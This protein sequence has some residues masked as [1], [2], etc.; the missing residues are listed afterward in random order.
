M[1]EIHFVQSGIQIFALDA[2]LA[3]SLTQMVSV[4]KLI[5]RVKHLIKLLENAQAATVDILFQIMVF[6]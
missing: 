1:S 2:L 5:L 4:H 3:H 6:V